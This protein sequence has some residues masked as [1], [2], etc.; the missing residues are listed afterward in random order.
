MDI[1]NQGI[2]FESQTNTGECDKWTRRFRP[3]QK[4]FI[5]QYH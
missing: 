2:P 1:V 5:F 4:V 3:K